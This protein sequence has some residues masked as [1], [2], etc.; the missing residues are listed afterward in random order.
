[1]FKRRDEKPTEPIVDPQ[2]EYARRAQRRQGNGR[3]PDKLAA[4]QPSGIDRDFCFYSE[5]QRA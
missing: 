4:D 5:D 3:E 2:L 1:M